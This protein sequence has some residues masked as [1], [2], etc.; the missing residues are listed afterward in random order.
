MT[1]AA[2]D[3]AGGRAG[4][5]QQACDEQ[6][7]SDDRGARL[8]D[9]GCQRAS[10]RH[11]DPAARVLAEQRH[12]AEKGHPHTEPERAHVQQVA[13]CEQEPAEA[14]ERDR[15]DVRGAAHDVREHVCEPGPDSSAVEAE[16]EDGCEDEP[17]CE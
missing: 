6:G 3:R 9:Q 1:R 2:Q 5:E 16:I 8:A 17:E 12:Q 7:P 14:D 4:D 10:D 11:P 15:Q 13:A